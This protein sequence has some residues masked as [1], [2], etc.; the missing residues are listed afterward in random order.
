MDLKLRLIQIAEFLQPYQRIWQ[1]EIMLMYPKPLECFPQAW[2]EELA[3]ITSP[4]DVVRLEKKD[5]RGLVQSANLLRFYERIEE[6]S[7]LPQ[8][9][10]LPPMPENSFTFL[11]VIPKKQHEIR[12]LA[13]YVQHFYQ[14]HQVKGVVDIGGGIGILAQTLCNQYN[15]RV[16]SLDMDPALQ[17]TGRQRHEKNYRHADNKVSYHLVKVAADE[18]KFKALLQPDLMTIG[19]HA[20]GQLS[21]DQIRATVKNEVRHLINFG[22]CYYKLAKT[23]HGQNISHFAQSLESRV[24]QS[25]YALT[26]ST[27][28]HK[29]MNDKD[30][31][32]KL[33]VKFYRYAM[34]FLLHD[35]YQLPEMVTL[36]N[37]HPKLY[38]ESFGVYALDQLQRIAVEP[39][40]NVEDLNSYF[41]DVRRQEL[42][43]KMLAAGLIRNAFGRLLEIYLLL[44]RA[45]YLEEHGYKVEV[46]EFF[47]EDKSPRNIG[48]AAARIS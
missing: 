41:L 20:C 18:P 4:E 26:L 35:E 45:I 33:K 2:V 24:E 1:N 19:L 23:E 47:D 8:A 30:Y 14:K 32:F 15:L 13:P 6:L 22:C 39:R 17:K 43:W 25:P 40:H 11:Y 16:M 38:A 46:M 7:Q 9:P 36:G 31:A 3:A 34:H 42:I 5:F 29:K 44:D 12:K 28:A 21:L 37:T 10:E 27:R 48:L